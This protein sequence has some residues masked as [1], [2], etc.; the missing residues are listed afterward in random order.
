MIWDL[1]STI[2]CPLSHSR[3]IREFMYYWSAFKPQFIQ[4]IFFYW[5]DWID[6]FILLNCLLYIFR[7]S[8]VF[9]LTFFLPECLAGSYGRDCVHNCSLTCGMPGR[10]DK[11][12]GFCIDGCQAGL[13]GDMC[14][15]GEQLCLFFIY[16]MTYKENTA[17][18]K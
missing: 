3:T 10:C 12:S 13:T 6:W 11:I 8:L 16:P 1:F 5:K 2:N 17:N 15:K 9:I 18:R 14:E 4:H 7:V